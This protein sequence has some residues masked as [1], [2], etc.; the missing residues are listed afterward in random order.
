MFNSLTGNISTQNYPAHYPNNVECIWDIIVP[1][2][3]HVL[4]ETQG[5]FD[6]ETGA[7]DTSSCFYD[8]VQFFDVNAN[9]E[10]VSEL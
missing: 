1:E 7:D 8:Y 9:G 3:Y 5:I 4:L 10:A 2:G 6:I